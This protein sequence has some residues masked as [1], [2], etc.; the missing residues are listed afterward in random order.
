MINRELIRI[1]VVQLTYA[2]YQNGNKNIDTAEKELFFS[3]SKAYDLYNYLLLLLV[4][5]TRE[6]RHRVEIATQ[7]AQREGTE[8]PSQKFAYNKFAVQLE[9]NKMLNEFVESQK[10]TWADDIEFVRKLCNQIESSEDYKEYMN[11][12]E[13]DYETDRELWRKLYKLFILNNSDLDSLLEEKSLYWND[14][15]EVVD[16]FVMKTIKRFEAD[17]KNKQELLPEY[18]DEEDKDFARKLFRATILNADQYQHYLSDASRNWDFSRLAYM[19]IVI[20]QIAIAEMLTFPNIPASVTINEFVDLAK[21]YSTSR[22]G[23]YINGMLDSIAHFFV[24]NGMM[25][26]TLKNK[27]SK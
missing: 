23:G 18:D 3:L 5:I 15:K 1:K 24:D 2:Y 12:G 14:D 9:E 21:L 27:E 6:E 19:D 16:T 4:D 8:V 25:M 20:M 7:R 11:A 26:K 13:S 10:L 17:K 22:S